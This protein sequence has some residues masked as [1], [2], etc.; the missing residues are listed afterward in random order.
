MTTLG[1]QRFTFS[2]E[3]EDQFDVPVLDL[4]LAA[5]PACTSQFSSNYTLILSSA[6]S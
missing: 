2:K 5:L 3:E 4:T 1:R 6:V